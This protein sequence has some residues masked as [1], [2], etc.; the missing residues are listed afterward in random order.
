MVGH[1]EGVEQGHQRSDQRSIQAADF[2]V[3]FDTVTALPHTHGITQQHTP[4]AE[5]P[6]VLLQPFGQAQGRSLLGIE[7]PTD[8]GALDPAV[9]RGQ[10]AFA[11]PE[12][13]SYSR[14]VQQIEHFANGETAVW[15][16]EQMLQGNQQWITPA[17]ALIGQGEGYVTRVVAL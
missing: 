2:V 15:Q 8:T 4:Q 5:P 9:Q 17:L 13:R 12:T 14:Y 16:L 1:I 7:P 11:D 3:R 10:V 6:A